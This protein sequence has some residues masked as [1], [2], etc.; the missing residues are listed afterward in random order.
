MRARGAAWAAAALLAA[1]AAAA[2]VGGAARAP[3]FPR[4]AA[5]VGPAAAAAAAAAARRPAPWVWEVADNPAPST[6]RPQP[7]VPDWVLDATSA[8]PIG[9]RAA[10]WALPSG[11]YV[12]APRLSYGVGLWARNASPNAAAPRHP[13]RVPQQEF[14]PS[15][16]KQREKIMHHKMSTTSLPA[17]HPQPTPLS[18]Y[19]GVK[20][21]TKR[22]QGLDRDS[23]PPSPAIFSKRAATVA[24]A[25][26]PYPT[27]LPHPP[28]PTPPT[29]PPYPTPPTPPPLPHPPYITPP[30]P[31]SP[32]LPLPHPPY[33]TPP[34]SPPL[35]HPPYPTPLI[36]PPHPTPPTHPTYPIPPTPPPLPHPL[37]PTPIPR[38]PRPPASR[39]AAAKM[40]WKGVCRSSAP[41]TAPPPTSFFLRLPGCRTATP[42]RISVHRFICARDTGMSCRL[43]NMTLSPMWNSL[44]T[45]NIKV[46]GF[47]TSSLLCFS[48]KLDP[49]HP[50]QHHEPP[51]EPMKQ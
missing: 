40:G 13:P 32:P 50:L 42:I 33:P 11:L 49:Q 22:L 7:G 46:T 48:Q 19:M 31:T 34:T 29:P 8:P 21:K 5:T 17:A 4:P 16:D 2:A 25:E 15:H 28:Y 18:H 12:L 51:S 47:V 44:C 6:F 41:S 20:T 38:P 30:T 1:A 10:A 14:C 9:R 43:S 3:P 24:R 39:P 37:Y 23:P 36:Q 26:S 35:P 27:P 45:I